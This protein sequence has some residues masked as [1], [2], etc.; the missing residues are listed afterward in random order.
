MNYHLTNVTLTTD[1]TIEGMEKIQALW[2]DITTG[3]LPL[4]C[5]NEHHPIENVTPTSCYSNYTS[6]E[7]GT[8]DLTIMAETL[9]FFTK[10][11]E[12]IA[13]GTYLLYE[14]TNDEG[15][16]EACTKQAWIRIWDDQNKQLIKRSFTKDY[17]ASIPKAFSKDNKAHCYVYIAIQQ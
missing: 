16:I 9:D 15:N 17:E 7:K 8:Y 5:D 4:L 13:Q 14:E 10:M 11:E 1:N 12:K 6:D 3:N 2:N